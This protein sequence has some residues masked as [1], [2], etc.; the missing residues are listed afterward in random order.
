[1]SALCYFGTD[2]PVRV[3]DRILV[4]RRFGRSRL[5]T[6]V[7]VPGQVDR[8]PELGDSEWAFKTDDGT[9]YAAGYFAG[10][11]SH[12]GRRIEFVHRAGEEAAA[13]VQS[14]RIPPEN[15]SA[16]SGRD[17][18]ALIG[19]GTLLAIIIGLA[20]GLVLWAAGR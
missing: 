13:V 7:Y 9:I 3:G 2:N 4:H 6:V 16:Q 17:L 10:N 20:G 8:D 1:M 5:G 15:P 11:D 19:C 14:Y 12:A 18:L